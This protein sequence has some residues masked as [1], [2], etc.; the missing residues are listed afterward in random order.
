LGDVP[1]PAMMID[2]IPE[3]ATPP[4]PGDAVAAV[5]AVRQS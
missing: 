3:D 1:T 2:D 4:G 5:G